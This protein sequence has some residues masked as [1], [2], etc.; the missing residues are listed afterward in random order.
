M[1]IHYSNTFCARC[2]FVPREF[3]IICLKCTNKSFLK[4]VDLCTGPSCMDEPIKVDDFDHHPVHPVVRA[5]RLVHD[6]HLGPL[7]ASSWKTFYRAAQLL[8]IANQTT[9][10]AGMGDEGDD[11]E[12]TT[13]ISDH[14]FSCVSCICC[15]KPVSI[16][17]WVCVTCYIDHRTFCLISRN[18][19]ILTIVCF[20]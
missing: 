3:R 1:L 12:T 4:Q 5:P 8:S 9:S 2:H 16:P 18:A 6:R 11:A 13:H 14:E 15:T 20:T 7:N 10:D 19:T 17:F